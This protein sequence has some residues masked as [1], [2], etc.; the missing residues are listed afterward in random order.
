VTA[1][2]ERVPVRGTLHPD[3]SVVTA[4]EHPRGHST[5]WWGMVL[6]I[7]TE[8]ATFAAVIASYY[9]LRFAKATVWP[10]PGE[11]PPDLVLPSIATAV[12]I[13]SCIPMAIAVRTARRGRGAATGLANFVSFLGGAAFVV[14][15]ILDWKSEWPDSTLSK[16]AYGSLLYS[17]TGLHTAHVVIGLGM[18]LFLVV[19][20]AVGRIKEGHW[21]PVV[22]VSLY[23]YFMSVLAVAVYLTVYVTPNV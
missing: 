5:G 16:D 23:W 22:I 10:P 8:A 7:A 15:Q 6:F 14:L 13:V 2:A 9:Y 3:T 18:L 20:A 11:S 1:P 17:V 19:A 12:L 4:P 21:E